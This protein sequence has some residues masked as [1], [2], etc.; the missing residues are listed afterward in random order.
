MT[1]FD[2]KSTRAAIAE[3]AIGQMPCHSAVCDWSNVAHVDL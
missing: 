2:V 3:I 1:E